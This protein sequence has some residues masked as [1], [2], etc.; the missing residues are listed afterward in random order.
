MLWCGSDMLA[1]SG[2]RPRCPGCGGKPTK[3]GTE[4]RGRQ[5]WFC[6]RCSRHFQDG[7]KCEKGG[8]NS[9]P[10]GRAVLLVEAL[11][12]GCSY[13]QA[14]ARASC[15]K[16]TAQHWAKSLAI[17]YCGCG[18]P[19]HN[20]W[21]SWRFAQSP[22]R[23]EWIRAYWEAR[24]RK[25]KPEK[26]AKVSIPEHWPFIAEAPKEEHRVVLLVACAIP[27]SLPEEVRRE[28]GQEAV[29]GLLQGDFPEE[30]LGAEL[31]RLIRAAYRALP[32]RYGPISLDS[33]KNPDSRPLS[34]SIADLRDRWCG[35]AAG[36]TFRNSAGEVVYS[37]GVEELDLEAGP[38]EEEKQTR[39]RYFFR[40]RTPSK[41][42]RPTK[43]IAKA[44][45][46]RVPSRGRVF[47]SP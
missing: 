46:D 25:L 30:R 8:N 14:A 19:R 34:E 17:D 3:F 27:P 20:G 9:L 37:E 5:R 21:C 18:R 40:G 2:D 16:I 22:N 44:K 24:P 28:V 42:S 35:E 38:D 45:E 33:A 15:S 39:P 7:A 11:M 26:R 6:R 10:H 32:N 36:I 31:P 1:E 41:R 23:Q 13:R 29:L 12:Q 4:R 47:V 43:R